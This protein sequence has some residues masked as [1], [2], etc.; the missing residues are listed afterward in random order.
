[1]SQ[2]IMLGFTIL[3]VGIWGLVMLMVYKFTR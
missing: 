3:V 1:M 2:R